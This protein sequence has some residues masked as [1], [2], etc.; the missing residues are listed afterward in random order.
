MEVTDGSRQFFVRCSVLFGAYSELPLCV[1]VGADSALVLSVIDFALSHG[2]D[3]FSFS[4]P[5]ADH[6]INHRPTHGPKF[7][8]S[9]K[10]PLSSSAKMASSSLRASRLESRTRPASASLGPRGRER[11]LW[12]LL[13]V[14]HAQIRFA[15]VR[16][17]IILSIFISF[18][19]DDPGQN[20]FAFR[21]NFRLE[22]TFAIEDLAVGSAMAR[23]WLALISSLLERLPVRLT[24]A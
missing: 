3:G 2:H 11:Y 21:A 8:L 15:S 14:L 12:W 20:N 18:R 16:H 7:P 17:R 13:W 5:N 6:T 9:A 24:P 4:L 1:C 23:N 10:G 19:C 22:G